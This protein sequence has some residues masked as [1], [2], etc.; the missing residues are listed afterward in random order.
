LSTQSPRP[1]NWP[2]R[3]RSNPKRRKT[4]PKLRLASDIAPCRSN[5]IASPTAYCSITGEQ[6]AQRVLDDAPRGTR[7]T[8]TRFDGSSHPPNVPGHRQSTKLVGRARAASRP[9][10]RLKG[11]NQLPKVVNGISSKTESKLS[12]KSNPP[13]DSRRRRLS[14]VAPTQTTSSQPRLP[15]RG[16]LRRSGAGG[17]PRHSQGESASDGRDRERPR[18][19]RSRRRNRPCESM[20]SP[21]RA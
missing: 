17:R 13:L 18:R 12:P 15:S 20:R 16:S 14:H 8:V 6:V 4:G 2:S 11:Q 1:G 10:R 3:K 9:W 7:H 19:S 21:L 5:H